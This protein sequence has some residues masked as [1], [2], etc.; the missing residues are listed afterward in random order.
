MAAT[1]LGYYKDTYCGTGTG[2]ISI[3]FNSPYSLSSNSNK[4]GALGSNYVYQYVVHG[5]M[6]SSVS[7][8]VTFSLTCGFY[9]NP[10]SSS[11]VVAKNT[12]DF[13]HDSGIISSVYMNVLDDTYPQVNI[14]SG[15]YTWAYAIFVDEYFT[16]FNGV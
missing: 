14:V 2:T 16:L 11:L 10:S 13:T 12:R 3:P 8:N 7:Y 9:Y 1:F 4:Y 5:Q 15:V 6:F